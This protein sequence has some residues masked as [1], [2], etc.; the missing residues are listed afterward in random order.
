M[1]CSAINR[2]F[3]TQH[4]AFTCMVKLS[5]P[6]IEHTDIGEN[7]FTLLLYRHSTRDLGDLVYQQI[8]ISL[9]S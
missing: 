9:Y 6:S 1:D 2:N 4:Y 3:V 7:L 8:K 5:F